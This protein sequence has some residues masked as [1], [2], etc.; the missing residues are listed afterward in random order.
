MLRA[1]AGLGLDGAVSAPGFVDADVLERALA[2]ALCLLLPSRREG[3]GRVVVEAAA[4]GV[5][6][7]VVEGPDN[8]ATEL[9]EE[10]VNGVVAPSARGGRS[11]GRDRPRPRGGSRASRARRSDWFRR[12]AERL[13][14]DR[15]LATVLEAYADDLSAS[16]L[17]VLPH[18]GGGGETYVDFLSTMPGYRSTPGLPRAEPDA[19]ALGARARRRRRLPPGAQ[20]RPSARARRGGE[21]ALPAAARDSPVRRDLQRP[22]PRTPPERRRAGR[23]PSS[24]S[25]PIA[26]AADRMICVSRAERDYLAEVVA[27]GTPG[28][29][30]PQ[31]RPAAPRLASAARAGRVREELG[32]DASEPVGIWVGSLDERK[33][34]LAA[35]RAAETASVVARSSSATARCGHRSSEA[36]GERVRVL[37]QRDDVPRLLAA[38]DFYVQ[39]SHRE[40][41]AFSLLE[42][43]AHGLPPVVNDLPENVEAVGDA[44]IV[45]PRGD[46]EAL[47]AAIRRVVENER[48]R[49][50]LGERARQ[51]VARL[52]DAEDD[53]R[54]D[55]RRLRRRAQRRGQTEASPDCPS[56]PKALDEPDVA[57][58]GARRHSPGRLSRRPPSSR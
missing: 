2:S 31:Q 13:S 4:R 35:I 52:F 41:L 16:V 5:P 48:E 53:D 39:T 20:L 21:R 12:N 9:V 18:P 8:A 14:L 17:H 32:L 19:D 10:G 22:P 58:H 34:P 43:M 23:P 49:A 51:R 46:E 45:V 57:I 24:I 26:L 27:A 47:V 28:G 50:A 55:T 29:R 3:Y 36:A 40:G 44:G 30:H 7:V 25:A 6:I 11:R 38:A 54:A 56:Q 1:I 42:A 37:G 33:D 15:S